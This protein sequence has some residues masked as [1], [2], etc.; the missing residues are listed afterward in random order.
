VLLAAG[1]LVY[2][3][4]LLLARR[5]V[6]VEVRRRL[7]RLIRLGGLVLAA[8]AVVVLAVFAH[9]I[10][11]Q[12]TNPVSSQVGEGVN[13]FQSLNSSN[14]WRWW[15]EAWH[16]FTQHPLGGTG[17]ATFRI[18]DLLQRQSTLTANEPHN[19]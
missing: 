14:R 12:F 7:D 2:G 18:T 11:N 17:A 19:V 15:Q 1:G 9:R 8:G 6:A 5:T 16:A 10:W 13:R 4:S 3:A